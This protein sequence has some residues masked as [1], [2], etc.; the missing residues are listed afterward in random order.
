MMGRDPQLGLILDG[1]TSAAQH[2]RPLR[3]ELS[4]FDP[5]PDGPYSVGLTYWLGGDGEDH[6]GQPFTVLCGD[7]RAIA[8][9]VPSREIAEAIA[10]ALNIRTGFTV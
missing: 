1:G 5:M 3:A 9:S 10:A 4:S 8:G 7:G 2:K 6:Q